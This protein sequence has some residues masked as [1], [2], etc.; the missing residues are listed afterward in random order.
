MTARATGS[1]RPTK[2]TKMTSILHRFLGQSAAQ[3][4]AA[5]AL[6]AL[7]LA[8]GGAGCGRPA[9]SPPAPAAPVEV[10]AT[11]A[12]VITKPG[13]S[14]VKDHITA[15]AAIG[16]AEGNRAAGTTGF[17]RSIAYAEGALP[18]GFSQQKQSFSY[19]TR[20]VSRA[21][22]TVTT[23]AGKAVALRAWAP[24][25]PQPVAFTGAIVEATAAVSPYPSRSFQVGSGPATGCGPEH[26]PKSTAGNSGFALVV[27]AGGCSAAAKQALAKDRGAALLI[28]LTSSRAAH[29]FQGTCLGHPPSAL[30]SAPLTK[31][32]V[33][34]LVVAKS[35]WQAIAGRPRQLKVNL[36]Y[37]L[38]AVAT[39]NLIARYSP[40]T[41]SGKTFI[42]GGHL[43]SVTAGSGSNDNASGVAVLLALADAVVAEQPKLAH[44]LTLI[45]WG[46]EEDGLKGSAHYV[47]ALT[48]GEKAQIVGYLNLDMVGSP[49]FGRFLYGSEGPVK[50]ALA[51]YYRQNALG[52]QAIAVGA[53]SDHY[54]FQQAGI[55][56]AGLFT[57]GLEPKSDEAQALFGGEAGKSYDRCY[58][59]ACD[60]AANI[61]DAAVLESYRAVAQTTAIIAGASDP[62]SAAD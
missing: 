15:L 52:T 51:S 32:E 24:R 20:K 37:E 36:S 26:Y 55:A 31:G 45:F 21:E 46:G 1:P 3:L 14:A 38:K 43:D 61:N 18:S 25:Q 28:T 57:G 7:T 16:T 58:H 33:A 41:S 60:S 23:A 2:G 39:E 8:G 5:L 11:W 27:S 12:E 44:D 40:G 54:H 34:E 17:A 4:L 49:N 56:V 48:E 59:L 22:F 42:A 30:P 9:S 29:G 50:D 6:A 53:R 35:A 10:P 13:L 19:K 47:A 62:A